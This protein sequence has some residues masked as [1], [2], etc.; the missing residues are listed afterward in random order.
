MIVRNFDKEAATW[1]TPTRKQLAC[2]V[3][4]RIK[5]R[6]AL[7]KNMDILDF[8]CGTGLVSLGLQ[9]Y[10]RSITGV[11]S[12][13]GMLEVFNSKIAALRIPDVKTVLID[14]DK[15]FSVMSR[16][17]LIVSNMTLHHIQDV[18]QLLKTFYEILYPVGYI[19]FTDLDPDGG[20]FHENNQGVFHQGFEREA[21]QK[22]LQEIGFKDIQ[23][24]QA[25]EITKPIPDGAIRK[26]TV[27]LIT[28]RCLK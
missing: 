22:T 5:Q 16:F 26:F 1:D 27:F 15:G 6:I 13:S 2:D 12:S 25:A 24:G 19:A 21:L 9:P 11:D 20:R 18:K 28:G 4:E 14:Q 7:T 3:V 23:C 10:V 17:H 8:G